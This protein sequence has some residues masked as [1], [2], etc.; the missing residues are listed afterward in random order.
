MSEMQSQP[1]EPVGPPPDQSLL[2]PAGTESFGGPIP[3]WAPP[4]PPTP[5]VNN[6]IWYR[7]GAAVVLAAVIAAA[8]EPAA[9]R[10]V[11]DDIG[12]RDQ[13]SIPL[14]RDQ[15][16]LLVHVFTASDSLE[17]FLISTQQRASCSGA[18]SSNGGSSREQRSTLNSQRGWNVQPDGSRE[19]SGGMPW[20]LISLSCRRS[21]TRGTERR[22]DQV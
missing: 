9:G 8:A 20:M 4:P 3:S 15:P 21:S 17:T 22:S 19:R 12:E 11:L 1:S 10:E 16:E 14:R 7:I 5:P 6:T 13:W 18:T 2:P